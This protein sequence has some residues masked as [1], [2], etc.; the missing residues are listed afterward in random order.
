MLLK[1]TTILRWRGLGQIEIMISQLTAKYINHHAYNNVLYYLSIH[2]LS[3]I[4]L[5]I[6]YGMQGLT[7]NTEWLYIN[8]AKRLR[9]KPVN[10]WNLT[11]TPMH[12][13]SRARTAAENADQRSAFKA[14]ANGAHPS[15]RQPQIQF[16]D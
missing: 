9:R 8:G 2:L 15:P 10:R 5:E 13:S 1:S 6:F 12:Q 3:I 16:K 11:S 4:I 7:L 14:T